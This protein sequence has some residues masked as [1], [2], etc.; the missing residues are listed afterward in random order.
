MKLQICSAWWN[1][2]FPNDPFCVG[3]WYSFTEKERIKEQFFSD[4]KNLVIKSKS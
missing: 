4:Q 1:M 2:N 3:C